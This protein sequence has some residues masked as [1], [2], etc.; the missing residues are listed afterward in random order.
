M[1]NTKPR[2]ILALACSIYV[3]FGLFNAGIGP[4][5]EELALRTGSTLTAAGSVLTFLFLGALTAQ[6]VAG[7][8]TDRFGQKVI[9]VISL[10]LM[11]GGLVGFTTSRALP[12]TLAMVFITGLG[13]GG[14]DLGA[15]LIV[16]DAYPRNNTPMLNLLHFFFGA[17]AFIGPVMV[18]LALRQAGSGLIVHWI[19]AGLFLVLAAAILR[20][21]PRR[22]AAAENEIPQ[23]SAKSRR[24]VYLSPTLWVSGVFLLV[25]VGMEYAAG[26]WITTFM[27]KSVSML[28]EN[29][30]LVTSVFWGS[31]T[32]GRLAG[33]GASRKLTKYQLLGVA[34]AI[35]AAGVT[36]LLLSHAFRQEGS[37]VILPT[38][39]FIAII[40]FSLGTVYPTTVALLIEIFPKDQGKAVALLTAMGSIG[41]LAIPWLAGLALEKVSTLAYISLLAACVLLMLGL[42][43]AFWK[44]RR[45]SAA[46]ESN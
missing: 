9:L 27:Q 4:V 3:I 38:I 45:I 16:S 13:Q 39:L 43:F 19:A 24:S 20:L 6:I 41:G 8:L 25:Y 7:P 42:L 5:L 12:L 28:I 10:V 44:G 23:A 18:S 2:I 46:A 26:S 36:G 33:A 1:T 29:G 35:T 37:G 31:L 32:L 11:A 15:N 21:V 30:A 17:G 34:L 40:G 22:S 14:V